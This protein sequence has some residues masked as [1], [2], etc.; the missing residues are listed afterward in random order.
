MTS[1][2]FPRGFTL[3]ELLVV[4]GIIGVL[5]SVL[6]P[7]LQKARQQANLIYCQSNLRN[8]GNLV[9]EY[10][11]ENHGYLPY[12][13]AEYDLNEVPD[14]WQQNFYEH[15]GWTWCDTLSL[16]AG[17]KP[18]PYPNTAVPAVGPASGF[19]PPDETNQ[20]IDF[21][22]IFHDVDVPDLPRVARESDYVGNV[23]LFV[24]TPLTWNWD[25]WSGTITAGLKGRTNEPGTP[26][27]HSYQW[28]RVAG[29]IQQSAQ[30]AMVWDNSLNLNTNP[31]FIG[32]ENSPVDSSLDDWTT[33]WAD[34]YMYPTPGDSYNTSGYG[35]QIALG[36][37]NNVDG[38][39]WSG[40]APVTLSGLKY[41]NC[42]W[43]A[44]L[45]QGQQYSEYCCNMRFRHLS[46][47]SVNILFLDGH[48]E[49]RLLGVGCVVAREICCNGTMPA[50]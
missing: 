10:A 22:A 4:I 43:T 2:R 16:L 31:G 13:D 46:N 34:C 21:S 15:N 42:D 23:R 48:V 36:G 9:Q 8:I 47:S 5:I 44:A 14:T 7:A 26:E 27:E 18:S 35:K 50:N 41:D 19:I 1:K 40:G 33:D 25:T 45:Y 17:M 3:V 38:G 12:G 49:N 30:V 39:A 20:A 32:Q 6:L 28:P 29:S 37:T 24:S 11:A